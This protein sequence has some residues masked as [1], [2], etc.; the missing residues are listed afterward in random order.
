MKQG[1]VPKKQR[2]YQIQGERRAKWDDAIREF[3][4]GRHW[5]EDGVSPWSSPSFPVP[6]KTPGQIRVVVDSRDVNSATITDAHP[7]PRIEYIS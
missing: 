7:F 4:E 6:K 2:P 5:L 3:E 1:T